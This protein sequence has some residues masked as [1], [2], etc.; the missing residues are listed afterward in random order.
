MCFWSEKKKEVV[1]LGP[2][3]TQP[4]KTFHRRPSTDEQHP[5]MQQSP[6]MRFRIWKASLQPR[7]DLA[8]HKS[9]QRKFFLAAQIGYFEKVLASTAQYFSCYLRVFPQKAGKK[10]ISAFFMLLNIFIYSMAWKSRGDCFQKCLFILTIFNLG[11]YFTFYFV[12]T[13]LL[14]NFILISPPPRSLTWLWHGH[15]DALGQTHKDQQP[16]GSSIPS[17]MLLGERDTHRRAHLISSQCKSGPGRKVSLDH[18][19]RPRP[20]WLH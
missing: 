17:V 7:G 4:G 1:T 10:W 19:G 6:R 9:Q 12:K 2:K 14:N 8:E 11:C 15:V 13:V 20:T 3:R 16:P 18:T 5:P